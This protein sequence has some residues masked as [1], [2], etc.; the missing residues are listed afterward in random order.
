[1]TDVEQGLLYKLW[2]GTL[3]QQM[4]DADE[5]HGGRVQAEPFRL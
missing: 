4:N 5:R 1:M 3:L 2:D